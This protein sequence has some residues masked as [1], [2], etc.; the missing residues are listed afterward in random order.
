MGQP[1]QAIGFLERS[2]DL[3]TPQFI[4]WVKND[5]ELDSLCTISRYQV[6]IARAEERLAAEQAELAAQSS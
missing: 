2:L 1:D 4:T 6:L 5:S 3:Q